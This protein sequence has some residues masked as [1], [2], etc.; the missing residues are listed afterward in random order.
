MS[1]RLGICFLGWGWGLRC[2]SPPGAASPS[3]TP[4]V[5]RYN[6][7]SKCRSLLII[8]YK[9][10]TCYTKLKTDL[11]LVVN[12][13]FISFKYGLCVIVCTQVIVVW[14]NTLFYW[15]TWMQNLRPTLYFKICFEASFRSVK[16]DLQSLWNILIT[17]T[18]RLDLSAQIARWNSSCTL[19]P[20]R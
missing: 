11:F 6:I 3:G 13:C 15:V 4:L 7:I 10:Y 14:C 8:T 9:T 17:C 12:F 19:K 16:G 1:L 20:Q 2:D 18:S 5:A